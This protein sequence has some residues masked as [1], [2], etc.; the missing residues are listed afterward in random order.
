M[1]HE[2]AAAAT[3]AA[4]GSDIVKVPLAGDQL[5]SLREAARA[6]ANFREKQRNPDLSSQAEQAAAPDPAAEREAATLSAEEAD[7]AAAER[8]PT[9]GTPATDPA[10]EQP[11]ELPRSWTK[12]RAEHWAKPDRATQEFLLACARSGSY[13]FGHWTEVSLARPNVPLLDNGEI[14][15]SAEAPRPW[16]QAARAGTGR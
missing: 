15:W 7:A 2:Q 9:G 13:R 5:P 8:Q 6:V 3:G 1:E 11:L 16:R 4:E 12:D 10:R 14:S